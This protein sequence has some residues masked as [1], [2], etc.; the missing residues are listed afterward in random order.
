MPCENVRTG[1]LWAVY[2]SP[3]YEGECDPTGLEYKRGHR[4]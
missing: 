4:P 2:A 3:N 1:E